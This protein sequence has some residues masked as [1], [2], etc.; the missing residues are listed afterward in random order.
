MRGFS[1][2][3]SCAQAVSE[4]SLCSKPNT[5]I[6]APPQEL[7]EPASPAVEA[8]RYACPSLPPVVSLCA[9]ASSML[10]ALKAA[11]VKMLRVCMC[12]CSGQIRAKAISVDRHISADAILRGVGMVKCTMALPL[13]ADTIAPG[14]G[15]SATG[16]AQL[17]PAMQTLRILPFARSQ[18]AVIGELDEPL[19][20]PRTLLRR[21]DGDA[22]AAGINVQVGTEIEFC[23]LQQG[24]GI[25][26]CDQFNWA[27]TRGL[28]QQ[29]DFL[30]DLHQMLADQNIPCELIHPESAPGQFEVVLQ[31]CSPADLADRII[32]TK[33]TIVASARRQS[34]V[35]TF[36][37]KVYADQAGSGMHLHWSFSGTILSFG[38]PASPHGVSSAGVHFMAGILAHLPALLGVTTPSM[39]GFRRL[40]PGCWAGVHQCWGVENK[41]APLRLCTS[42]GYPPHVELKAVDGTAN[43]YLAIG[44]V[45]ASGL[46]G[47]QEQLFLPPPVSCDPAEAGCARLPMA[48]PESLDLLQADSMLQRVLGPS[49]GKAYVGVKRAEAAFFGDMT[50]EEEVAVMIAK[51]V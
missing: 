34:L 43:P 38:D 45:L 25:T 50:L 13:Y 37:P 15:L 1:R 44:L 17:V 32:A 5:P 10:I 14:C 47:I 28:D 46:H 16:T 8:A 49:L 21:V 24:G 40:G 9:V 36:V 30:V 7:P 23:L 2:S 27:S 35:A 19:L 29:A 22:R 39:N 20:C 33:E 42:G 12:D 51:G 4:L 6:K 26:P 48:L 31:H 3:I 11:G 41:E 18:A